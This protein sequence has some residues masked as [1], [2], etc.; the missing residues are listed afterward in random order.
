MSFGNS[1]ITIS[2][3]YSLLQFQLIVLYRK[4]SYVIKENDTFNEIETL[5]FE[6]VSQNIWYHISFS[7]QIKVL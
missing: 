5:Y 1:T 2:N 7:C 6:Q 3:K 4:T